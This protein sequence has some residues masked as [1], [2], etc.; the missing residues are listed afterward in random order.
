M[1]ITLLLVRRTTRLPS[2]VN[3]GEI[4]RKIRGGG[5]LTSPYYLLKYFSE[6]NQTWQ[7]GSTSDEEQSYI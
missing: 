4:L 7:A 2:L 6:L 1:Y 5:K 3:F